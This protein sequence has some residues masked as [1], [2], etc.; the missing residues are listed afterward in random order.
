M[1]W[2][3]MRGV[4][5]LAIALSRPD[6]MPGRGFPL[7]AAFV[8]LA[9]R[10]IRDHGAG[11]GCWPRRT[12]ETAPGRLDLWEMMAAAARGRGSVARTTTHTPAEGAW[13]AGEDSNLHGVT[14]WY[15]KPARL[16]IPPPARGAPD[17]LRARNRQRL[18]RPRRETGQPMP[19]VL[20]RKGQVRSTV[21]TSPARFGLPVVSAL[22]YPKATTATLLGVS[23]YS[24]CSASTRISTMFSSSGPPGNQVR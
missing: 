8:I 15:L 17:R 16:P 12:P 5:V 1:G 7:V 9:A 4:V 2:A 13:C 19:R 22:R 24:A 11:R 21:P 23:Q 20:A 3:G 10:P 18:S 6:A 14:H